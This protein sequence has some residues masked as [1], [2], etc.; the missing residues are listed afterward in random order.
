[1]IF[2]FGSNL[3]GFH[4]KGAAAMAVTHYGA[5]MGETEGHRGNSYAIPTKAVNWKFRLPIAKIR[6]AVDRFIAYAEAHPEL[7]F[8]VTRVGCGYAG[9]S[10]FEMAPLFYKAP[11][12][13]LFDSK[14]MS[15]LPNDTN[16]WGTY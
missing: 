12:N 5:V 15:F 16:Y 11:R 6:E 10:D 9:Y 3:S 8:H 2:V 7:T 13:C 1:M 14:W 4:G